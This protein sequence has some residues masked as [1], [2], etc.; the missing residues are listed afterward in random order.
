MRSCSGFR[1]CL[2][3]RSLFRKKDVLIE[4]Q[5]RRFSS[6]KC[7]FM[8]FT[9][10]VELVL[11]MWQSAPSKYP[12]PSKDQVQAIQ[13]KLR[14]GAHRFSPMYRGVIPKP[15]QLEGVNYT[16]RM[17]IAGPFYGVMGVCN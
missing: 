2:P 9:K 12:N 3:A 6:H 14:N 4:A 17:S 5:S 10:L 15:M 16:G 8:L 7:S 11:I 13:E 1:I